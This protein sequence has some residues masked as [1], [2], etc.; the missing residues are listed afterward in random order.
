MGCPQGSIGNLSCTSQQLIAS[1]SEVYWWAGGVICLPRETEDLT[2]YL[3]GGENS[4]PV[5]GIVSVQASQPGGNG[6]ENCA[7]LESLSNG[8]WAPLDLSLPPSVHC[9]VSGVWSMD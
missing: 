1:L 2:E 3:L 4:G 8:L 7:P 9:A 5:L 6:M